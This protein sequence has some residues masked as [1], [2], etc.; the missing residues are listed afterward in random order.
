MPK[1]V[2]DCRETKLTESEKFKKDMLDKVK[3]GTEFCFTDSSFTSSINKLIDEA[4]K[5]EIKEV[6]KIKESQLNQKKK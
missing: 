1:S 5:T 3:E 4:W 6:E 2:V